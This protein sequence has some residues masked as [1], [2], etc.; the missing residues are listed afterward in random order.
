MTTK[1]VIKLIMLFVISVC[2]FVAVGAGFI[3]GKK[4][5]VNGKKQKP[6]KAVMDRKM[7]K[8]RLVCFLVML[9]CLFICVVI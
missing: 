5:K 3:A 6:E 7:V 8:I 2:A 1:T 4:E 9:I